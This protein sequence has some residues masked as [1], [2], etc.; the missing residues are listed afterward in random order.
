MFAWIALDNVDLHFSLILVT[1]AN[2]VER[3]T[4]SAA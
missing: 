3:E 2:P 1:K 4:T